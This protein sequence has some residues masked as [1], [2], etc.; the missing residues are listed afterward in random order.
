MP[1]K[2]YPHLYLKS[3]HEIPLDEF[4]KKG[5]TNLVF[6]IDNT[7]APFDVP[8][9][10]EKL[11]EFFA[12]LKN[13]GFT[14]GLLSNNN[15]ERANLFNE[16]LNVAVEAKARKPKCDGLNK[17]MAQMGAESSATVLIGDQIFT[18][19][20]CGN[21]AGVLTVLVEPIVDYDEWFV[22][23]K[24]RFEKAVIRKIKGV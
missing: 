2:L 11:I 13:M 23:I 14:V 16:K 8:H 12:K 15:W 5:L 6:D 17:L 7:L 1:K 20:W 21:R 19:V 3:V 22:K 24:R 10:D 18:D 9:A 4:A